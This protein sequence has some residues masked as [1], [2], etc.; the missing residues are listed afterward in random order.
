MLDARPGAFILIGNGDSASLHSA[1]F[2]FAD[3]IIP[4][5][6]SYWVTLVEKRLA[7]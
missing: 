5:G 2:D 7:A 4:F 6:A 1:E 3:E